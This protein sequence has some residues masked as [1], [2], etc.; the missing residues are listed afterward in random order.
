MVFWIG[1]LVG[2]AFVRFTITKGFYETWIILFNVVISVYLAIFLRPV[3]V[4]NVHA[5]GG[6]SYNNALS[7]IA[8]AVVSFLILYGI[9][10][11]FFMSQFKIL[12][13]KVFDILGAGFLG[14]L[15]G[16]LLWS[17]VMVL[18]CSTPLSEE[19]T[20]VKKIG[21]NKIEQTGVP[22]ICWWGDLVHSVVSRRDNQCTTE[23]SINMLLK[24]IEVNKQ[25]EKSVKAEQADPN[26]I[27]TTSK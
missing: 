3:I 9:S 7:M 16:F 6:M 5:T 1:I 22:Y 20:F 11:V 17:F 18:I 2:V 13:S 21:L 19:N 8:T 26:N 4:K 10:Y 12:F 24:G 25:E 27:A 15:I 23:Q 14:F